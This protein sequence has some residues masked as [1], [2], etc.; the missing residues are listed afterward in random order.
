MNWQRKG[1]TVLL[2]RPVQYITPNPC[3]ELSRASYMSAKSIN[4]NKKR[5]SPKI[6]IKKDY[7][8][9]AEF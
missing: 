9:F 7:K 1:F 3:L 5:S 8:Q 2:Y 6:T 4:M